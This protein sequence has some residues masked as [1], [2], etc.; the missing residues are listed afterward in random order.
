[1]AMQT[2]SELKAQIRDRAT[3]DE[4]FRVRLIADPK[5]VISEEFGIFIPDDF[6]IRV[7]EDSTT[8]AHFIL[9][10]S[11][12]LTDTDLAQVAGGGWL[13]NASSGLGP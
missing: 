11:P 6:N 7:H 10:P 3:E 12:R 5:S 8:T 1:M 13:D 4:D 2:M 9:P